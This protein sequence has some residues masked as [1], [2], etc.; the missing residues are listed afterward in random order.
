[1]IAVGWQKA[2]GALMALAGLG[3]AIAVQPGWSWWVWP[4]ILLAPDLAALG[5]LAGPRIGAACYNAL[6]IYGAGMVLAV[7]GVVTGQTLLIALG[8]MW[9]AHIGA[10]RLLGYGLKSPDGF[11]TTHLGRIAQRRD[12]SG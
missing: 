1:M 10:D 9:I 7:I 11:N 4:L 2:E 3:I 12:Q 5:Y 8:G 6:H